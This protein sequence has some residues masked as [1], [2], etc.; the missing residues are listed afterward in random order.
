MKKVNAVK[1]NPFA[2]CHFIVLLVDNY[3]APFRN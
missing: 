3:D 2:G 1:A